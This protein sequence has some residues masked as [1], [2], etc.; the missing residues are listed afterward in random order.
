MTVAVAVVLQV[1]IA[2]LGMF[3]TYMESR[4]ILHIYWYFLY[5]TIA[6]D[7]AIGLSNFS[8]VNKK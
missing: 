2:L 8:V 5:A 4:P 6:S 3:G 1:L 7:V